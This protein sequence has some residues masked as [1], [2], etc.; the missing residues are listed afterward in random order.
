MPHQAPFVLHEFKVEV[1][2]RCDL[3]CVHCSSDAR[4]SNPLE[5]SRSDCLR[6]VDEAAAMGAKEMAFSGGEPLS[7]PYLAEAVAGAVQRGLRV[8]VY[9]SGSVD[10]FAV[11]ANDLKMA[12]VNRLVF[13]V[14]GGTST[15]HER[16]TRVAG[17]FARTRASIRMAKTLGL[18]PEIHFVPMSTN[19]RELPL[20]ASMAREDGASTISVLRLVPQGRGYLLRRRIL[21]RVQNLELRRMVLALRKEGFGVRT[22]SPYNFLMVNKEP[23]CWA[24][25]DRLVIG[26]DMRLYP[27]DAFKR[28]ES[29]QLVGT[30]E[31]SELSSSRL[32]DCWRGSPYLNAVRAFLET[33]FEDPCAPCPALD[34]CL[35]GCL[36]Q[37]VI[38]SGRLCK[39]AD[40]DCLNPSAQGQST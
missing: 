16:V 4:P 32:D 37:K 2:Y 13:S 24:A 7:W 1:T 28:I 27:C 33:D 8:T 31:L 38:A 25:I 36:A 29:D 14:F 11:K 34:R 26:P 15:S 30:S 40:P 17:S 19:Y 3:N 12:G 22:G 9:T 18:N 5:M 39:V 10:G 20:V 21:S 23:G 6:I 35:S